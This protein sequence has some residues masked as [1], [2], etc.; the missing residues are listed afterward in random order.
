VVRGRFEPIWWFGLLAFIFAGLGGAHA[1]KLP[2]VPGTSITLPN[3]IDDRIKVPTIDPGKGDPTVRLPALALPNIS[4]LQ[5]KGLPPIHNLPPGDNL[6]LINLPGVSIIGPNLP[7]VSGGENSLLNL[8]LNQASS[9]NQLLANTVSLNLLG[10]IDQ[11]ISGLTLGDGPTNAAPNAGNNGSVAMV[12]LPLSNLWI[13]NAM[14]F[15]SGNHGGYSY[16]ASYGGNMVTG[17]TLPVHSSDWS[18]MPGVIIDA[19]PLVGLK[20][21][22]FHVGIS[23]GMSESELEIRGDST[24]R[25]LGVFDVGSANMRAWSLGGFALLTTRAWYAGAAAGGTWGTVEAENT[26]FGAKSDFDGSSLTSS[27]FVGSIVPLPRDLRLD[28]RGTLGYHR[29]QGDA[30]DDTLG[31]AYGEH[32]LEHLSGTLSARLFTVIPAGVHTLRPYLQAGVM[33]RFYYANDVNIQGVDFSFEDA[34]TSLFTAGGIDVEISDWL[35]LSAGIRQDHSPDYDYLS[36]R[37]GVLLK[38]Y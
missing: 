7:A 14:T 22:A 6:L 10:P 13:W 32:V 25:G 17:S 5:T 27:L 15:G 2:D 21:G 26:V 33:H 8:L 12:A 11:I 31:I 29:T 34:D 4:F 23:A 3:V 16:Q 19:S 1:Q 24:L 20:R 36:G 28:V 38:L 30:H 37:F 9:V 35:Q 18:I